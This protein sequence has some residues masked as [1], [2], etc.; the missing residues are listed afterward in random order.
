[1]SNNYI[2]TIVVSALALV[3]VAVIAVMLIGLF[4][5]RV[6]NEKIFA[7][8]GPAFQTVVGCFVGVLGSRLLKDD[9]T[10]PAP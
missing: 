1:M 10:P 3:M 7:I 4:D 5:P 2:Y 9:K 6:D 8:L